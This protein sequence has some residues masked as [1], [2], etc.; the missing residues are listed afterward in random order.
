LFSFTNVN[1]VKENN[2]DKIFSSMDF[3]FEKQWRD[4]AKEI[5]KEYDSEGPELDLQGILFLIG[6]QEL[7]QGYR[8]FK[9][10]EKLALLH[11]AICAIL[12]PYGYYELQGLDQDGWPHYKNV[13]K[14]PPISQQEQE[15]LMKTAVMEYFA[16]YYQE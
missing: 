14:L 3:V 13:K 6:V 4:F 7:G 8:N 16:N 1:W 9:K 5:S 12:K 10:D 11:I 15:K 2:F